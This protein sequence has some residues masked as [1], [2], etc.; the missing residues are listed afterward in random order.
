MNRTCRV[1]VC[2][3]SDAYSRALAAFLERDAEIEVAGRFGTPEAMLPQLKAIRPD[4]ILLDL[5]V[6]GM[7]A[8]GAIERIMATVPTPILALGDQPDGGSGSAAE[9]LAAGALETASKATLRLDKPGDVWA[10]A[11]RSRVKRLGSVQLFR[12][13]RPGARAAAP[14]SEPQ[15]SAGFDAPPQI[16]GIGASTGGPPAL[17]SVLQCLPADYALPL[18][19]VQHI[20]PGFTAGLVAWLDRNLA[21]P[22]RFAAQGETAGPGVWFAPDDAHVRVDPSL[23]FCLDGRKT[24][25]AHRPAVDELFESLAESAGAGALGVVLTGMGR[26]GAEGVAAICAAGGSVIAQD[27]DTSAVYGMPRAAVAAGAS[28]V[29]ALEEIGPALRALPVAG[30]VA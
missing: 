6:S 24:R 10:T 4:L 29:L 8:L 22:V 1:V 23:R 19:V 7:G 27:E 15:P 28:V 11:V 30:A 17:V 21:L 9:A 18:V 2:E 13:R 16:A 26:D 12:H 3:A 25:G 5:D 14:G 20:T